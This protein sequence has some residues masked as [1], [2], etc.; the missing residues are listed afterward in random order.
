MSNA[1]TDKAAHDTFALDLIAQLSPGRLFV[2]TVSGLQRKIDLSM[3]CVERS[4]A[5]RYT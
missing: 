2:A 4:S 3:V 1:V 5:A